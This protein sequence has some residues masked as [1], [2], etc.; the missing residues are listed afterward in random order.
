[1]LITWKQSVN[2]FYYHVFIIFFL[3][4]LQPPLHRS[5]LHTNI[6]SSISK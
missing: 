5:T 1:M 4:Q 3:D 6:N 2:I